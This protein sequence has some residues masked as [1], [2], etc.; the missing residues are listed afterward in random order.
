LPT[1]VPIELPTAVPTALPVVPENVPELEVIS[2]VVSP[3]VRIVESWRSE[4]VRWIAEPFE[5]VE[6][7][8]VREVAPAE[9]TSTPEMTAEVALPRISEVPLVAV[10]SDATAH[11][12]TAP[13]R[14]RLAARAV[15]ASLLNLSTSRSAW[16]RSAASADDAFATLNY[17]DDA[18]VDGELAE[19]L[20]LVWVGVPAGI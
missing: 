16:R 18:E 3:L 5:I 12:D 9:R 1:E 7:L 13:P 17:A 19:D 15:D 2:P 11:G 4:E 20:A 10:R 6:I 14:T 8:A